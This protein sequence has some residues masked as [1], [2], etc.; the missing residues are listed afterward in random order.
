M[1]F[2]GLEVAVIGDRSRVE[3]GT[4]SEILS[5][6]NSQRMITLMTLHG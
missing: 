5:L 1:F 2:C 4:K 3:S 6:P